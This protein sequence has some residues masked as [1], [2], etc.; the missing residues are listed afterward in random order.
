MTLSISE[1]EKLRALSCTPMEIM[2][3]CSP[4]LSPRMTFKSDL[5]ESMK[6]KS[7]SLSTK[8]SSSPRSATNAMD[9]LGDSLWSPRQGEP[10]S[11]R[12]VIP[13]TS[14]YLKTE[15][16]E[17]VQEQMETNHPLPSML[18]LHYALLLENTATSLFVLLYD[19]NLY[20]FI[21]ILQ[22]VQLD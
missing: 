2:S 20:L 6:T 1:R 3:P 11:P 8:K 7:L 12:A 15:Y 22:V 10:L 19:C 21:T 18:H 5:R 17:A 14:T 4:R 13:G 9:S 16:K